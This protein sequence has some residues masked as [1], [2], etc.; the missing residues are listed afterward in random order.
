M[1]WLNLCDDNG[2]PPRPLTLV[3]MRQIVL[4][5]LS[6]DLDIYRTRSRPGWEQPITEQ[7]MTRKM[8]EVPIEF[9]PTSESPLPVSSNC[10]KFEMIVVLGC[11]ERYT[12]LS[13]VPA[14]PAFDR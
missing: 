7:C 3:L 6:L 14:C 1:L 9:E 11:A 13:A 5:V 4:E 8:T 10:P 12:C 2:P